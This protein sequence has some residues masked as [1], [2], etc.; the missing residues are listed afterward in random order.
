MLFSRVRPGVLTAAAGALTAVFVVAGTS[1]SASPGTSPEEPARTVVTSTTKVAG[2][3]V[4]GNLRRPDDSCA[5]EPAPLDQGDAPS[6]VVNSGT[7]RGDIDVPGDPQRIVALSGPDLDALCALGLQGRLVAAALPD[8]SAAQPSYLGTV[9]HDLPAVGTRSAPDVA[10]IA[11][12]TPDLILGSRSSTP[13]SYGELLAIAPTVF[14][15][16]PDLAWAETL[17]SVGAATGRAGTAES[18]LA[19]FTA[20]ADE[21]GALNDARHFQVSVVQLSDT[22][23]RVYGTANFPGSVLAAIGA[24]RPPSQRFADQPYVEIGDSD[25]SQA[26]GD[27]I[28]VSFGSPAAKD[29]APEFM[30]SKAWRSLS[31]ARDNRVYVVNNEVWQTGQGLIAA[32]GML[33]D[34]RFVNSPLN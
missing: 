3:G 4:L 22:A 1:C 27:V 9:I 28:F 19:G 8:G 26:D 23:V 29:R 31:A 17:R 20:R 13:E 10:A 5:P 12:A 15:G 34:L 25:L 16:G 18:L 14:T 7:E 24:D 32:R 30:G 11:A 6:R 2:A 33:D 21:I